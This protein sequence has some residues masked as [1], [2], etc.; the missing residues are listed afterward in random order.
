M[1]QPPK[2]RIFPAASSMPAKR[3]CSGGESS[4]AKLRQRTG[5][6]DHES[7]ESTTDRP[8][9]EDVTIEDV[10]GESTLHTVRADTLY[11]TLSEY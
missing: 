2:V 9:I 1:I 11:W 10:T 8:T 6:T 5:S 7:C 4:A 3:P